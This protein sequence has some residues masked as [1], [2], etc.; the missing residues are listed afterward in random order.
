MRN[1]PSN[2]R[3]IHI[4]GPAPA[5]GYVTA[6]LSTLGAS[7]T[8]GREIGKAFTLRALV[9]VEAIPGIKRWLETYTHL[10]GVAIVSGAAND[11]DA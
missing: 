8:E 1:S 10:Q 5:L 2:N 6:H 9:P 11:E 3:E 4:E 7:F